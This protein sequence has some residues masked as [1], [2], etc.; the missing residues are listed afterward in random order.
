MLL[1]Y[2]EPA[3]HLLLFTVWTIVSSTAYLPI[4]VNM[5]GY[6]MPKISERSQVKV[7]NLVLLIET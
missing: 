2:L 4:V 1:I 6:E 5:Y 7:V 3:V